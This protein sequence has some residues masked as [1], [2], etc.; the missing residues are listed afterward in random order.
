MGPYLPPTMPYNQGLKPSPPPPHNISI[1]GRAACRNRSYFPLTVNRAPPPGILPHTLAAPFLQILL[2][3]R[4]KEPAKGE[5][6][7]PGGSMELGEG[8]AACAVREVRLAW[9]PRPSQEQTCRLTGL[10][11]VQMQLIAGVHGGDGMGVWRAGVATSCSAGCTYSSY[12][13]WDV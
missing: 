12:L 1:S 10:D 11:S 8:I 9:V 4:A 6:C 2:I 5:W 3:R 7:F 13:S